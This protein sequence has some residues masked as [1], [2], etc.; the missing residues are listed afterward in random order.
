MRMS[1]APSAEHAAQWFDAGWYVQRYPDVAACGMDPLEHY[2]WLGWRLQRQPAPLML[3]PAPL[4]APVP[5]G[6]MPPVWPPAPLGDYWLPQALRD[7]IISGYGEGAVGLYWYLCSVMERWRE[8]PHAFAESEDCAHILGRLRRLAGRVM[9]KGQPA[10]SIIVPVYNNLI[11]TL[12]CLLSVLENAGPA[13]F[14]LWVADDGSSDA[15]ASLVAQIGG[16]VRHLRQPQNLGFLGNCNAAVAYAIAQDNPAH[17][18]LLN[19]DP[20]VLPGWLD[21][22][23]APLDAGR[24]GMT[25]AKLINWDGTLQE[26]GG[27]YWNDGSAW[28]FGRGANPRACEFNYLKETDYCS[29]AAIA[30]TSGLWQQ[31]GS[32]P[33][34]AVPTRR[35][36]D[37]PRR[38]QP[39][40][41]HRGGHQGVSTGQSGQ[42]GA[43][44][45][46]RSGRAA[47]PQ[48]GAGAARARPVGRAAPCAGG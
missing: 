19:N 3:A 8:A 33:P 11:D 2:L 21:A 17:I 47:L 22:L 13:S 45:G 25:G 27:I 6:A 4:P 39:W 15:T 18:V 26:A 10:A 44:L 42:A 43:A 24:A 40:A 41:R 29:G 38:A 12:L 36:G 1:A 30:V 28:N 7:A 9:P 20:L 34:R 46:G 14:T 32:G 16:A 23:L 31:L 48:R 5:A 37:P 35:R